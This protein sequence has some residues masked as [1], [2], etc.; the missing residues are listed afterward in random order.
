MALM[1]RARKDTVSPWAAAG[2]SLVSFTCGSV[3]PLLAMV[4]TPTDYRLSVTIAAVL[5]ALVVTGFTAAKLSG[6]K[7][8]RPVARNVVVGFAAMNITYLVGYLVN[9]LTGQPV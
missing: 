4:L 1:G 7:V 3:I 5:A 6:V 2:A 9:L 8:F